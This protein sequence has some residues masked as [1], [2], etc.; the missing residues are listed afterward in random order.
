MSTLEGNYLG[1]SSSMAPAIMGAPEQPE[2]GVE[3]TNSFCPII[4]REIARAH[5]GTA[6][7]E[8]APDRGTTFQVMLP[9]D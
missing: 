4:V 1:W 8:S 6:Q 5:A 2:L 7:V 9:R 3:L